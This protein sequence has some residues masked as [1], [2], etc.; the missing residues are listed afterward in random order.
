MIPPMNEF[1]L[2]PA[3]AEAVA[4]MGY[5]R[6]TPIQAQGIPVVLAGRDLIGRALVNGRDD[7]PRHSPSL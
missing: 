6:P 1:D 5:T 7:V 4:D 2:I 3:L